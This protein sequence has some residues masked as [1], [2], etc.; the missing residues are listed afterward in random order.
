M[1]SWA[2][3][4]RS[5]ISIGSCRSIWWFARPSWPSTDEVAVGHEG[6]WR[7]A[8]SSAGLNLPLPFV[9]SYFGVSERPRT[10]DDKSCGSLFLLS[11]VQRL[12]PREQE[13]LVLRGG[14][15]L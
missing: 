8:A 11:L 9:R 10:G 6:G 13:H 5:P 7:E 14:F 12:Q 2:W 1:E 3:V 15:G 4:P